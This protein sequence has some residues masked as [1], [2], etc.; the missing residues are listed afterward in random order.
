MPAMY[1][2]TTCGTWAGV[3]AVRISVAPVARTSAA[4]ISGAVEVSVEIILLLKADCA[5]ER[6][7]APPIIWKTVFHYYYLFIW[8]EVAAED[9]LQKIMAVADA[10]SSGLALT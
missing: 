6:R 3:N 1:A 2:A 10:I 7:N 9:Y 4:L 8:Q 5:A